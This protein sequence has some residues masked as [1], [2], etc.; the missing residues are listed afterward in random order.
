MS[1]LIPLFLSIW[2]LL[3]VT[4]CGNGSKRVVETDTLVSG[5]IK[6]A[7]DE[8]FKPIVEEQ[9]QVFLALHPEATITPIY[10]SEVEAIRYLL[11]DSVRLAITTRAL[12]TQ[13]VSYLNEKKFFPRS[14]PL[15]SDGVAL[16][17][18]KENCDS[19]LTVQQ[20]KK[21]V[22][23]EVTEWKS[24]FPESTLGAIQVVFD[25]PNSSS[26]RYVIDSITAG[27]P[28][29]N[30]L[31]ALN[32]NPEVID[33]VATHPAAMG[34][35]G[36]NW[37]G[38]EADSTRLSFHRSIRVMALSRGEVAE[39]TNSYQPFQAYLALGKY[40]FTRTLYGVLN[41]PKSG[42][43][44]GFLNFLTSFRGQR[45]ILKSGLVPATEAVRIVDIKAE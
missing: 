2:A 12:T 35:I 10:C 19:L 39:E 21:M 37:I 30:H 42:L 31:K 28:L 45:I 9:L 33:Y 18:H 26:V 40:P 27:K 41:D 43:P 32:T 8:S 34:I 17:T 25:N 3:L 4:S 16:I 29:L 36:V 38:N 23:G 1:K 24:L 7:V 13:E 20:F 5:E 14:I 22:T 15:A 11:A 44:S 6:I